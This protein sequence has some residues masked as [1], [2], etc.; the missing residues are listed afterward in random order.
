MA[1]VHRYE[2]TV[3]QVMGDGI[4]ALFGAPLA[5]EDYAVR[6]YYTALHMQEAIGRY[7]EELRRQQGLDVQIRLG[8][9]SGEMVVRSISDVLHMDYTTVGQTTP[10]AARMEQLARPG[11]A[12]L[13][14]DTLRLVGGYV[15]V[16]HLGPEPVKG[17]QERIE[18]YEL[19]RA[20]A[21]R[22]RLQEA[23]ARGLTRFLGRDTELEHLRQ[24][25]ARAKAGHGQVVAGVGEAGV[26][27]S[28]LIYEGLR[29]HRTQGWLVLECAS[30]SCGKASPY[31]PVVDLL[32]RYLRIKDGD[33]PRTV[34]AS[35]TGY[36]LTLDETLQDTIP[37]LLAL[38]DALP[39]DSPFLTLDPPQQ[40]Q[41]TLTAL[42]RMLLRESQVQPLLLV[43]EEMH[44]IDS[45]KQA[46]PDS[47]IESLPTAHRLLLVNYRPEYHHG[48]GGS[49]PIC[50]GISGRWGT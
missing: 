19:R 14:A 36:L 26:G 31:A 20:G 27:K 32:K 3:N 38:L 11:T 49:P 46:V 7:V 29:S 2:G 15:E 47:L 21:V 39:S 22:S 48:W 50:A 33:E 4:M 18:V 30:I 13:T 28:R 25:L 35:V 34:R 44:W 37:A 24:A 12:L 9:N 6:A 1:A 41:R 23:V 5:H 17:L 8:L 16:T 10:L 40:R 43:F 45:E 42:K